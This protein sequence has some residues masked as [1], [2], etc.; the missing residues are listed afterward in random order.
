[1]RDVANTIPSTESPEAWTRAD[2]VDKTTRGR[3]VPNGLGNE[4]PGHGHA[5]VWLAPGSAPAL[6]G[7]EGMDIQEFK[8]A[9]KLLL[10]G[11]KHADFFFKGWKQVPLHVYIEGG[12]VAHSSSFV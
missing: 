12:K 9:D 5:A 1:M 8:N 10:L 3:D 2:P 6:V 7:K 4:C 11:G